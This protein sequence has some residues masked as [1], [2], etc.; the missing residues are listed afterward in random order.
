M[1]KVYTND[2]SGKTVIILESCNRII[3]IQDQQVTS[4]EMIKRLPRELPEDIHAI[5][6]SSEGMQYTFG[7][8]FYASRHILRDKDSRIYESTR[9]LEVPMVYS[10]QEIKEL[11]SLKPFCA[12]CP[13]DYVLYKDKV[14]FILMST[15]TL[16]GIIF[17][18]HSGPVILITNDD[19]SEGIF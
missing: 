8:K 16:G 12:L 11:R 7:D 10:R 13:G 19:L 15:I 6:W 2:V 18:L 5:F 9:I 4:S 3:H 1:D 14:Y 17:S